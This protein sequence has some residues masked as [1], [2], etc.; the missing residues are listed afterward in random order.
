MLTKYKKI[1]KQSKQRSKY[2][3]T[4]ERI[5]RKFLAA[6][7]PFLRSQSLDGANFSQE[8]FQQ[9]KKKIEVQIQ[10]HKRTEIPLEKVLSKIY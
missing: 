3:N 5:K 1:E 2:F 9:L 6:E 10:I 7:I 4:Q 8:I